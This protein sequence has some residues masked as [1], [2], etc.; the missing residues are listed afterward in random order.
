MRSEDSRHKTQGRQGG[1]QFWTSHFR[2]DTERPEHVQRKAKE[3]VK[4]PEHESDEEQLRKPGGLSLDKRRLR[5]EPSLY[6]I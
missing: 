1:V 5:G 3:L 6:N 2:K 4:G